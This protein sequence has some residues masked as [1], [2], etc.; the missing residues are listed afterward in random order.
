[1]TIVN[2]DDVTIKAQYKSVPGHRLACPVPLHIFALFRRLSMF[3]T[4]RLCLSLER[5]D[6][7]GTYMLRDRTAL[8]KGNGVGGRRG[9]VVYAA[10]T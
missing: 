3:P 5:Q 8:T 6:E 9:M 4:F 1:M 2:Y 10:S 7:A